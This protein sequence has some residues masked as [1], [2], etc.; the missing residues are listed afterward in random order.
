MQTLRLVS[1]NPLAMK[2]IYHS[3]LLFYIVPK[4][5]GGGWCY[6]IL[7]SQV[8]DSGKGGMG[9]GWFEASAHFFFPQLLNFYIIN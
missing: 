1:C 6:Y 8:C 5:R 9:R 3:V 7:V 2:Y 4:R